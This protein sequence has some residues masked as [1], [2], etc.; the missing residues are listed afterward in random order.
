VIKAQEKG[1][2]P[3][4]LQQKWAI[5]SPTLIRLVSEY[6]PKKQKPQGDQNG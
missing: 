5:L 6:E 4:K 2:D 1:I 3:H